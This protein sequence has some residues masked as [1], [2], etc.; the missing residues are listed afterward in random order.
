MWTFQMIHLCDKT[1]DAISR[2][3]DVLIVVEVNFFFLEGANESFRISVL[4]RPPSVCYGNFNPKNE[5]SEALKYYSN[6]LC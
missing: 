1:P 3:M 6:D 5:R 4:P 2:L